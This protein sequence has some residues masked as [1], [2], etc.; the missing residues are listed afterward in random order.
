MRLRGGELIQKTDR[1]HAG[2]KWL[3]FDFFINASCDFFSS[4][5]LK[6]LGKSVGG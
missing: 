5:K 4:Q 6:V 2:Q 3:F 1:L